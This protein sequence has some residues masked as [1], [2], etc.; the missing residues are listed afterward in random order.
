MKFPSGNVRYGNLD[1]METGYMMTRYNTF[2]RGIDQLQRKA[3]QTID[4]DATYKTFS[5]FMTLNYNIIYSQYND[6]LIPV[7]FIRDGDERVIDGARPSMSRQTKRPSSPLCN[8][9]GTNSPGYTKADSTGEKSP[10]KRFSI[11][12]SL[13]VDLPANSGNISFPRFHRI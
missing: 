4:V 8:F 10:K 5:Q 11:A 13:A 1:G 7:S 2:S 3:T 6:N 12:S 9:P